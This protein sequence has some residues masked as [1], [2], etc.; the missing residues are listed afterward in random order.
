MDDQLTL[1][2]D[3]P[4]GAKPLPEPLPGPVPVQVSAPQSRT[5]GSPRRTLSVVAFSETAGSLLSEALR[6]R[7]GRLS[8]EIEFVAVFPGAQCSGASDSEGRMVRR[9][10][11]PPGASPS[12]Q[13]AAGCEATSGLYILFLGSE[14]GLD[15]KAVESLLT[16]LDQHPSAGVCAPTASRQSP[17]PLR[18]RVWRW[19]CGAA[20]SVGEPGQTVCVDSLPFLARRTALTEAGFPETCAGWQVTVAD[21]TTRMARLGW[22]IFAVP[23]AGAPDARSGPGWI[24]IIRFLI[25]HRVYPVAARGCDILISTAAIAL[26]SP[27]ATVRLLRRRKPLFP[28]TALRMLLGHAA[29]IG[30][31][32]AS[33]SGQLRHGWT[34]L[35]RVVP[36]RADD[37]VRGWK[38]ADRKWAARR[39]FSFDAR[40]LLATAALAGRRLLAAVTNRAVSSRRQPWADQRRSLPTDTHR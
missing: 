23:T 39:G 9:R 17:V 18:A 16:I 26:L 31:S 30:A 28:P 14:A 21:L 13:V 7:S 32:P 8:T 12:A 36:E 6:L 34:G 35:W 40:I 20:N 5:D 38:A 15:A 22:D 3:Q 19:A 27:A 11:L 33:E 29:L 1:F 24:D 25:S 10:V 4:E 2:D 37:P